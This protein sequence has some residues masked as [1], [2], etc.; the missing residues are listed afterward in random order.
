M[1]L[2]DRRRRM[3]ERNLDFDKIIDRK[4]TKC[5]KYDFAVERGLPEDVLPLWVA[6]MDFRISS[7]I[8]DALKQQAGHAIYGYTEVDDAYFE[9]VQGWMKKHF[10]WDVTRKQFYKTPGVVF[11]IANA[12]RAFTKEG[13]AVLIQQPVYYPFSEVILDNDRVLVSSD[14]RYDGEGHYTMDFEDLERK[15][16]EY[17]VKLFL[18]CNPHNPVGRAWSREE[19]LTL[20]K[21]CKKYSVIVFSDEIHADFVWNGQHQVFVKTA[22]EFEEFTITATAPSKT[23]NI[24]GLQVSNIFIQNEMLGQKF[25]K[26]YNASGYSQLNAAGIV[27]A[28]AAYRY[29]EEW[30][31]AMRKYVRANIDFMQDYV[32]RELPGIRMIEPEG[33]YLVWLDCRELGY[34]DQELNRRI[35]YDGKLWL[36]QGNIFGKTGEGFERVNVAC[37]RVILEEALGRLKRVLIQV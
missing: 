32:K 24:A 25:R 30:Y 13:D 26:A 14:L 3:S 17:H 9:A 4:G 7:Y 34:T 23:F 6:D 18:L 5:L 35:I 20:G 1:N 11:A 37:P 16:R 12:I 27:A 31:Q 10:D 33:T 22:P 29:G 21:I 19:L 36:D 8:E 15:I 28:E 2:R